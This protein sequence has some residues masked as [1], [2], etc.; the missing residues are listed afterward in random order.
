MQL[1]PEQLPQHLQ[2]SLLGW[3]VLVGDEP[4]LELEATD[5]IRQAAQAQ[6]FTERLVLHAGADF[7]WSELY[8]LSH[9]PSLFSSKQIIELQLERKPDKTGQEALVACAK[10]SLPE[11]CWIVHARCIDRSGQNTQW[12]KQFT[13]QAGLIAVWPLRSHE[14]PRWLQQRA[15]QLGLSLEPE[16]V[17][18]L[19]D[20]VDGHLLA[21]QQ[22]LQ[23][24]KL[25]Y[26]EQTIDAQTVLESVSDHARF[27]V[28]DFIGALH[29]GELAKA[30]RMLDYFQASGTEPLQLQW[31][32]TREVRTMMSLQERLARGEP[33]Q[34]ACTSVGLRGPQQAVALAAAERIQ[35]GRWRTLFE[36]L[37]RVDASVKGVEG[38]NPWLLLGQLA[39][40]WTR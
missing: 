17:A 10:E 12:F 9:A 28:F 32:L 29:R 15:Q 34:Q 31:M 3:Y 33:Q 39:L 26:D 5:Q 7:D 35:P 19:A 40:R 27:T 18:L 11:H 8:A 24:L 37:Q 4:L 36:L 13:H 20:L 1:R 38:L 22:E 2:Q 21:A 23:K 6:G 14:F 25:L 30:Q 16:A